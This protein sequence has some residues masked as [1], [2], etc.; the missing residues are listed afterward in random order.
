[1][2]LLGDKN[3][4]MPKVLQWLPQINVEGKLEPIRLQR[5]ENEQASAD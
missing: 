5:L 1:M 4:Y 2:R 3:W